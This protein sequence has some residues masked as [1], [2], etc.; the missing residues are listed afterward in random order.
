MLPAQALQSKLNSR[1]PNKKESRFGDMC[2]I[3]V[4]LRVRWK[5]KTGVLSKSL[6]AS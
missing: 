5:A 1:S 2:E 6:Q 4:F 3:P